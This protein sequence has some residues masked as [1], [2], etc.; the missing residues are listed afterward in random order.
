MGNDQERSSRIHLQ[1]K[2]SWK[3]LQDFLPSFDVWMFPKI[4]EPPNHPSKNRFSIINHPFWGTT[5]FGNT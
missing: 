2:D 4:G 5:I 1:L 3:N